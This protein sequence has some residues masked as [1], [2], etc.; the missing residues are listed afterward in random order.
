MRAQRTALL[1]IT[2]GS[3]STREASYNHSRKQGSH[4]S[5]PCVTSAALVRRF[6]SDGHVFCRQWQKT[7]FATRAHRTAVMRITRRS[8]L[9][10][11][12][13][14]GVTSSAQ[15][16]LTAVPAKPKQPVRFVV[17]PLSEILQC[18]ISEVYRSFCLLLSITR[19]R[20]LRLRP[21]QR[22]QG[23]VCSAQPNRPQSALRRDNV[24][25]KR[26]S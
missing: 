3:P 25:S 24:S 10:K 13:A 2:H 14:K 21:S 8:P 20:R 6:A 7:H 22:H 19:A 23:S 16:P 9:L 17:P 18:K 26:I 5:R 4:A 1:R 15:T 12:V 11:M